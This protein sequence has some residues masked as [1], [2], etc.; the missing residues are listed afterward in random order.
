MIL[1]AT[2]TGFEALPPK[3]WAAVKVAVISI[4]REWGLNLAIED[5]LSVRDAEHRFEEM[6]RNVKT[7]VG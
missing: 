3:V 4:G 2:A 7:D 6:L 5:S 1:K